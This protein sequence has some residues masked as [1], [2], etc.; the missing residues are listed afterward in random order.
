MTTYK[1]PYCHAICVRSEKHKCQ[2]MPDDP[3]LKVPPLAIVGPSKST[4]DLTAMQVFLCNRGSKGGLVG[5]TE[6]ISQD[7][8]RALQVLVKLK[9]DKIKAAKEHLATFMRVGGTDRLDEA[10]KILEGA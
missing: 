1:C 8:A 5:K 10:L 3:N 9:S 2:H 7:A 4:L 6:V